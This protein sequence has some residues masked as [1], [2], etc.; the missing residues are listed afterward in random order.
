MDIE[1]KKQI[2][3]WLIIL[4]SMAIAFGFGMSIN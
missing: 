3:S 4:L 2:R 1:L